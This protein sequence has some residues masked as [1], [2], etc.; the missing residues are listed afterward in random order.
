MSESEM[1]TTSATCRP[2]QTLSL[3]DNS[4]AQCWALFGASSDG[5]ERT[6][7]IFVRSSAIF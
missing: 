6:A 7:S 2:V 3:D 5:F 1:E 4:R